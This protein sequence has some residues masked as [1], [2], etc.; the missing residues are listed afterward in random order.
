MR[1]L[2]QN[3]SEELNLKHLTIKGLVEMYDGTIDELK[4]CAEVVPDSSLEFEKSEFR[5]GTLLDFES[6][7]L[8]QA[9]SAPLKTKDD[10]LNLMDLWEKIANVAGSDPASP[11]DRI[12]MNIFR[13][14]N[15]AQFAKD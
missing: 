1:N 13:H 6:N 15:D 5:E 11:S 2:N 7:V 9:A 10:I 14:M 8:T 4:R 3:S 12:A